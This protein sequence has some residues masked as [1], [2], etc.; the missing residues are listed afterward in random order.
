MKVKFKKREQTTKVI[1]VAAQDDK[2]SRQL[3]MEARANGSLH[4]GYH[5]IIRSDGTVEVGREPDEVSSFR[6]KTAIYVR[7]NHLCPPPPPSLVFDE[8][9]GL[10]FVKQKE[11]THG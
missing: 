10:E 7:E 1:F 5:Y 2:G 4:H 3:N 8:W 11:E 6:D 9:A